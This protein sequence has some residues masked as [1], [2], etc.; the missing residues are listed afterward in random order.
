MIEPD[1]PML[2]ALRTNDIN[3]F[4]KAVAEN[5]NYKPLLENGLDLAFQGVT[6]LEEIMRF[7]GEVY[8]EEIDEIVPTDSYSL[9]DLSDR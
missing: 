2:E 7:A 1:E 9:D 8:Q 3:A 5:K 4:M 6:S